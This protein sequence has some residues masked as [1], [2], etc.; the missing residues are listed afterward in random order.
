MRNGGLIG[1]H[2]N[3][4][5]PDEALRAYAHAITGKRIAVDAMSNNRR[6]FIV[7]KLDGI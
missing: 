3:G 5:T 4:A 7:P 6:E 1:E 2:G